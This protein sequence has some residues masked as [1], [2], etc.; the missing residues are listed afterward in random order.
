MSKRYTVETLSK[1]FTSRNVLTVIAGT[2]ISQNDKAKHGGIT[3]LE[4]RNECGTEWRLIIEDEAGFR[5]HMSDVRVVRLE[6]YG[7]S[8][9]ETFFEALKFALKV[10]KLQ[11]QNP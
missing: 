1:T 5:K 10:Y 3:V 6:L 9:A 11:R 4:L 7:D 2:N 8:E